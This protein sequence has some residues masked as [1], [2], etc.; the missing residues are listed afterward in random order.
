MIEK[1][2]CCCPHILWI[3]LWANWAGNAQA[4]DFPSVW[5]RCT[6]SRQ[7][8]ALSKIKD[9]EAIRANPDGLDPACCRIALQHEF[10]G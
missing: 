8:L 10:W 6:I 1:R 7:P 4:L 2:F 3:T 9:L 5:L